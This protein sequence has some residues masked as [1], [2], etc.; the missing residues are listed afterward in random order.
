M[1]A[2]QKQRLV[3][4]TVHGKKNRSAILD[5]AKPWIT[6]C[7][8]LSMNY[9]RY[10]E[11]ARSGPFICFGTDADLFVANFCSCRQTHWETQNIMLSYKM[12]DWQTRI[13]NPLKCRVC[14]E[15]IGSH[16][17]QQMNY[18]Y[19]THCEICLD[20]LCENCSEDAVRNPQKRVESLVAD[21]QINWDQTHWAMK[22][23]RLFQQNGEHWM[24]DVYQVLHVHA[25]GK[26]QW[27]RKDWT[28][29]ELKRWSRNKFEYVMDSKPYTAI[30][31]KQVQRLE[32]QH[33]YS[34]GDSPTR[35]SCKGHTGHI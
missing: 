28:I 5:P 15:A 31:M 3:L 13:S 2:A 24:L 14:K 1:Q 6:A 18:T 23:G 21:P 35:W 34:T 29:C 22:L 4:L 8:T 10:Q 26:I 30:E 12:V 27:R 17:P 16:G 7:R 20:T 19:F 33:K 11:R 25:G 32:D 9:L